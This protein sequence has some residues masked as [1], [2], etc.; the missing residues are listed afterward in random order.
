MKKAGIIG[1]GQVAR[2]LGDGFLSL[3]YS[4]MLGSREP[5]KLEDWK[6]QAGEGAQTGTFEEAARYGDIL[7]LAVK[8][9][10]AKKALDLIGADPLGS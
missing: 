7:I 2:V 3:G 5:G 6:T 9:G 4:V 8:G 1:S 10:A